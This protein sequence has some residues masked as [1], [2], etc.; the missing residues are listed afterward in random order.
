MTIEQLLNDS[1]SQIKGWL[2]ANGFEYRVE[3]MVFEHNKDICIPHE[4]LEDIV[5]A[6][7]LA[8]ILIAMVA[9]AT[10]E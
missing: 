1:T 2:I 6:H 7:E 10:H 8:Q 3:K 5:R 4:Y 9:E